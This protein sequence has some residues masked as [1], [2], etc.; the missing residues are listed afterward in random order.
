MDKGVSDY[1]V[2]DF[3]YLSRATLVKDERNLDKF[4]RV[5]GHIFKGL[6]AVLG[7][8]ID[9]RDP[10]G[11]AAQARREAPD[12]GGEEAD[13][14]DGR[15]GKA[16]GDAEEAARGAEGAPP[17]RQQVDRHGRHLAVRRLR[18]QSRG[19]AHRPGQEP[20]AAAR[21]R[22]GTS[23]STRTSTTPSSSARATSR[24]RC[25]GCASSRARAPQIELDLH[26]TIRID[27]AQRRLP[28]HQDGAGAAQ[29]GEGADASST[30]A[31]RWTT[32]SAS[33]RSCSRPR[34]SEFKHLEFF[35]FHNCLYEKL[36]KDNR[37]R[38]V[39]TFSTGAAAPHLSARLQGASSSA[40]P[41]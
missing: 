14:G 16:H 33:A 37:R 29:H 15:L 22:S 10:R 21:S 20:R 9:G 7:D 3:Y 32:T 27:R 40:T 38:H 2:D 1:S 23:A 12:R 39:D 5:F 11:V 24:S 25:G 8:G 6:E 4:D 34:A 19:R 17:G 35:Y 28:R 36:W 30:S 18:L 26:D 31:A 41:R 13:R